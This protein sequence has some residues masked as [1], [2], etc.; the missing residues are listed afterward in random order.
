MTILVTGGAGYIGSHMVELLRRRGRPVVVV[1]DL[2]SGHREAV[3]EGVPFLLA[4]VAHR[5]PV[6]RFLREQA[7][8]SILHFASRIQVGESVADP[9]LHYAGNLGAAIALLDTALDCGVSS[10]ILSSSAAVYGVPG[11]V[12]ITEQD[13]TVPI[14]PYGDTKLAIE[15][16]L[17]TYGRAYGL[18]WA[19]LRYFNAAG[20]D[21]AAG[22]GERHDP[23]THLIP[24]VL[25][26]ALGARDHVTVFGRDYE[27]PD[28]TCIRDYVHVC[29]LA[30]AHLAAL[31][32]ALGGEHGVFN[33]G[34]GVGYSVAQVI[35]TARAVTGKDIAVKYGARRAGDPAVLVAGVHRAEVHLGW[36]AKRSSLEE[37][38]RDAW[39]W[40]SRAKR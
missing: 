27:T 18:E 19:A 7:V 29:D 35:E 22:L 10:F 12:P 16:M 28:G 13:P 21:A 39:A 30:E 38:I 31:D 37:I 5:E 2:S 23:E 8:T 14:N 11:S 3:P 17:A 20:A 9:R 15:R 24:I 32:H 34:T 33:L 4:N 6:A 40:H 36:K 25:E 26:C 1:D